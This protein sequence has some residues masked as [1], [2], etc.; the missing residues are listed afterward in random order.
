MRVRAS[1]VMLSAALWAAPALSQPPLADKL[2]DDVLLYAGWSGRSLTFDG[3]TL[4][5]LLAEP[6]VAKLFGAVHDAAAKEMGRDKGDLGIF[7]HLWAMG[8]IAWQHPAAIGLFD[9]QLPDR[10]AAGNGPGEPRPIGALLVDLQKDRPAFQGELQGMLALAGKKLEIAQ[11]AVGDVSYHSFD[12][13][14]GPCGLGFIGDVFFMSLG[15]KAPERV[16]ALAKGSVKTLAADARFAAA[17]KDVGGDAVQIAWYVNVPRAYDVAEKISPAGPRPAT[18]PAG[19][20]EF[21]K[22]LKAGGMDRVTAMAGTVR[23]VDRCLYEKTRVYSPAPHRG[24]LL[25]PAGP[26]LPQT[27]L[28]GVPAD[29]DVV[30]AFRLDGGKVLAEAREVLGQVDPESV[31][32]ITGA[33]GQ[34]KEMTGVDVEKELLPAVGDEWAL[35]SAES[36]GGFLTGTVLTGKIEDPKAFAAV[37]ARLEAQLQKMIGR[38]A[39][40][41]RRARGF[42]I[43]KM[44]S[45]DVEVHYVKAAGRGG[46][47]M[48]A[49]PAWAVHEGRLYVA[50]F[51]QVVLAAVAGGGEK[52]LAG[53]ADFVALRKRI[54]GAP[55][56]IVYVNAPRILQKVYGAAL[57]GWTLGANTLAGEVGP[58][59]SPGMLPSL[60][61]LRK[62]VRPGISAM[63][64]DAKGITRE[65]YG[66]FSGTSFF[67]GLSPM[68]WVTSSAVML[69]SM[70]MARMRARQAMSAAN[71]NAIGKA[72]MLYQVE[73]ERWPPDLVTLVEKRYLQPEHLCSPLS[74]RRPKLDA[75]GKPIGPFDYVYLGGSLPAKAPPNM[76]L[77]HERPGLSPDGSVNALYVDGSVRRL[78]RPGFQHALTKT[79]RYIAEQ[80]K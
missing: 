70:R 46:G 69:P 9:I 12:T 51:P 72:C 58:M 71:L 31:K 54:A 5:Q 29:A 2:P 3:S 67:W 75:Q 57:L 36:L 18:A 43:H 26:A 20:S 55:S 56:A 30:V 48:P 65:S 15:P 25:P 27:A 14:G 35:Y 17:M 50:A 68:Q 73:F 21:R 41:D 6:E 79:Q 28:A 59:F 40:E 80:V 8:K 38:P 23:I 24:L 1:A 22:A 39:T 74:G 10:E 49:A 7:N 53:S 33:L 42:T 19:P 78:P 16:V 60:P 47:S 37:L 64:A 66:S 4:G 44:T 45:G 34:F 77:A 76:L 52:P 61:K 32:A 11:S 13:P 63:S 62:Y